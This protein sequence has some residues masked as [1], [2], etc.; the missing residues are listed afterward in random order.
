LSGPEALALPRIIMESP[1][2]AP[3]RSAAMHPVAL[4]VGGDLIGERVLLH[5]SGVPLARLGPAAL[6]R[7]V[8]SS[9]SGVWA[10]VALQ[11]RFPPWLPMRRKAERP[12][13]ASGNGVGDTD[14]ST[15]RTRGAGGDYTR[16]PAG[17]S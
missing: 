8:S 6:S 1:P 3:M 12:A 9:V 10:T 11:Q 15:G 4:S 5:L 7:M 14:C 13:S 16:D 17:C 2:A